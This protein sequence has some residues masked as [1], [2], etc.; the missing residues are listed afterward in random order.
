MSTDTQL[1]NEIISYLAKHND[2]EWEITGHHLLY[3]KAEKYL[4]LMA[5]ATYAEGFHCNT[6]EIIE[7]NVGQI[8]KD[9]NEVNL[10]DLGPGYPDKSLPIAK[11]LAGK[12]P[13]NYFP[14]DISLMYLKI[15]EDAMK[16]Y[17][18]KIT[19][20]NSKFED[21][22]S[23]NAFK[24]LKNP[25]IMIGL[26]FMNFNC[27]N[28]L[29][30][31]KEVINN[32]GNVIFASE[33]KTKNTQEII[34]QYLNEETKN[35]AFTP[36]E[37]LGF[38][39]NFFTYEAAFNNN[40]IEISFIAKSNIES[41]NITFPKGAKIITAISNRYSP[42]DIENLASKYFKNYKLYFSKLKT[43]VVAVCKC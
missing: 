9:L 3:L 13:L 40:R 12:S 42:E 25:Y 2:L 20:V 37:I 43:T 39:P 11:F 28:I 22:K 41:E 26:T 6:V 38:N 8:F 4:N 7:E 21:L 32:N 10:I 29:T 14:V 35:F 5:N 16:P 23:A 36:L 15:A 18:T 1:K 17:C 24:D 27:D 31:L 30:L 33:L 34:Q 19:P